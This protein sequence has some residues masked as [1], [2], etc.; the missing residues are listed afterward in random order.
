MNHYE[1]A[2]LRMHSVLKMVVDFSDTPELSIMLQKELELAFLSGEAE[3][4]EKELI[5]IRSK[6]ETAI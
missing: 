3:A 2:K 4:L 6:Y 1:Y 5:R